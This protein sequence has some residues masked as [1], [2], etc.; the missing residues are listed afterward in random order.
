MTL[1][2]VF[3]RP[4]QFVFMAQTVWIKVVRGEKWV[5]TDSWVESDIGQQFRNL[6]CVYACQRNWI[7]PGQIYLRI[8]GFPNPL[9]WLQ[10]R[11]PLSFLE[12]ADCNLITH[13]S[14]DHFVIRYSTACPVSCRHLA[15]LHVYRVFLLPGWGKFA[16]LTR[17]LTSS[18]GVLQQLAPAVHKGENLHKHSRLAEVRLL[19]LFD[20]T[21]LTLCRVFLVKKIHKVFQRPVDRQWG[22]QLKLPP[23]DFTCVPWYLSALWKE[24]VPLQ[25]PGAEQS[26]ELCTQTDKGR[27]WVVCVGYWSLSW[28]KKLWWK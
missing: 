11:A 8:L 28:D 27:M 4:T 1:K 6:G 18:R 10:Q 12:K 14:P 26:V 22:H 16:R 17:A 2:N 25:P 13:I 15:T 24:T 20:N 19:L 7:S 5:L 21:S 23:G 3:S 9:S